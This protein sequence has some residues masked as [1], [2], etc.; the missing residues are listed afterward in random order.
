MII[1]D[2]QFKTV[3][4]VSIPNQP[5]VCYHF[6]EN[7][8]QIGRGKNNHLRID[9]NAISK[10]HCEIVKRPDTE[11]WIFRDLG[12]TNG[13]HLNGKPV[14]W[15]VIVVDQADAIM[16][17]NV[18]NL[19]IV[20]VHPLDVPEEEEEASPDVNPVAAAVARQSREDM[21]GTQLIKL[22]HRK[23]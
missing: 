4:L 11:Q 17:G 6:D 3:L 18:I 13:S 15:D 7:R 23:K 12:S 19:R 16:L 9:D 8:I 14:G 20:T 21:E 2:S 5:P 22:R 1:M 10:V